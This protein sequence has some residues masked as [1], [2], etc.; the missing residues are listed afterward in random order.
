MKNIWEQDKKKPLIKSIINV[1]CA[2]YFI[3][4]Y[5]DGD[6]KDKNSSLLKKKIGELI[7]KIKYFKNIFSHILFIAMFIYKV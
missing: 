4:F 1:F 7:Q 5:I 2:I 3:C 6:L